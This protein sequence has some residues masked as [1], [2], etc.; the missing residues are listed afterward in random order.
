LRLGQSA[1]QSFVFMRIV[2]AV[3]VAL[4]A[5]GCGGRPAASPAPPPPNEGMNVADDASVPTPAATGI[6][7]SW[8]KR[9]L[10]EGLGSFLRFVELDDHPVTV[11]GRFR[12][13]RIVALRGPIFTSAVDVRPGD[14]VTA[15]NGLPIERPEQAEAA[16]ESLATA[17]ELRVSIERDGVPRELA[18]PIVD[19]R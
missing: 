7:R 11:N 17:H 14:V 4:V 18:Y 16:F 9:M 10:V 2:V 6:P 5:W 3:A 19:D 12:G 8:L 13:F 15:V 1:S